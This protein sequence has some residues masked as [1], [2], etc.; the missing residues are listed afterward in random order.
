MHTKLW[1]KN[2]KDMIFLKC[3]PV[4]FKTVTIIQGSVTCD[5]D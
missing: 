4:P 2:K 3:L 1:E 5:R